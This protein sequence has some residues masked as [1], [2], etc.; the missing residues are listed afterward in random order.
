MPYRKKYKKKYSRKSRKPAA[1]SKAQYQAVK[2]IDT[3]QE[4]KRAPMLRS[5]KDHTGNISPVQLSSG[6]AYYQC[7]YQDIALGTGTLD[8]NQ[9]LSSVIWPQVLK[10]NGTLKRKTGSTDIQRFRVMVLRYTGEMDFAATNSVLNGFDY[11]STQW[12]HIC[13][14]GEIW[15]AKPF[16]KNQIRVLHDKTYVVNDQN[17]SGVVVNLTVPI[18]RKLTFESSSSGSS[19]VGAG[20]IVLAVSSDNE[21]DIADYHTYAFYKDLQ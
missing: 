7:P 21:F 3:Q 12:S 14:P 1:L 11:S 13:R 17:K 6:N 19:A 8:Q 18:R 20:N 2:K 16:I 5:E 9:R 15:S 4:F 10:F